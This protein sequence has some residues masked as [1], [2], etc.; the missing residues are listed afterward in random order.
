MCIVTSFIGP[1][2]TVLATIPGCVIGSVCVLLYGFI[3]S[4]G[5]KMFKDIDF[6]NMRNIIIISTILVLGIGGFTMSFDSI[7]ITSVACALIFGIVLN[8]IL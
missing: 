2:A 3:A 6:D 7:T 1:I 5:L 4:S 8:L